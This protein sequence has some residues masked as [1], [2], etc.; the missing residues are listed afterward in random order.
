MGEPVVLEHIRSWQT[1]GLID[2]VTARRLRDAEEREGPAAAPAPVGRLAALGVAISAVEVLVWLGIG[3]VLAA[4]YW[5]VTS[6][7][8]A[9]GSGRSAWLAA[10]AAIPAALAAVAGV[11]V[12]GRPGRAGRSGGLL[13]LVAGVQLGLVGYFV[14]DAAIPADEAL[15]LTVGGLAWLAAAVLSRRL[16]PGVPTSAGLVASIVATALFAEDWLRGWL[17]GRPDW[18]GETVGGMLDAGPVVALLG[19]AWWLATA[20]LIALV[21]EAEIRSADAGAPRR[22]FA[23]RVVAGLVAVVGVAVSLLA[24][25]W[26]TGPT[27][28]DRLDPI[29]G[30]VALLGLACGLAGLVAVTRTSAWLYP[31]AL[32]I[33]I[34]LSDLDSRYLAGAVGMGPALLVEGVVLIGAGAGTE[35]VRRRL[36]APPVGGPNG[37]GD[38]GPAGG[39]DGG[40]EDDGV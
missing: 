2:E 36:A 21:G 9:F 23:V 39:T 15:K 3:L 12:R 26:S 40:V 35:L 11:A 7:A 28:S 38:P 31:G 25:S 10:G 1:A 20:V 4:W 27:T 6:R 30:D 19:A 5:E 29:V 34:A 33:V 24:S 37:D 16:E 22:A 32:A 8:P 14:T 17:F 18:S 13:F